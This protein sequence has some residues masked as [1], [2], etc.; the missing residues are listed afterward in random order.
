MHPFIPPSPAEARHFR[1]VGH[2]H[3][4]LAKAAGA[5]VRTDALSGR[6]YISA[7][8]WLLMS[9]PNAL[10]RGA[11]DA[12]DE[13]GV[14]LPTDD[15]GRYNA[16][17]SVMRPEEVA[18]IGGPDK[19]TERG[20]SYRYS[21]G[22]VK[23]VEP[24]TWAGTSKV[25]YITV[26]SPELK[27]LR[28]SYG[29]TP[30]PHNNEFD[31]HVTFATRKTKVLQT[32]DVS[33]AASFEEENEAAKEEAQDSKLPHVREGY[34]RCR[35]GA[36][37]YAMTGDGKCPG[38]RRKM[39]AARGKA[40]AD[41]PT[42]ADWN[43]PSDR[44]D[45]PAC[46]V[47]HERGDGYCNSCGERWPAVT[48][49]AELDAF[50]A[51]AAVEPAEALL[52]AMDKVAGLLGAI[53]KGV[54]KAVGKAAQPVAGV[55]QKAVAAV[56][57]AAQTAASAA[58]TVGHGAVDAAKSV[59][60][61]LKGYAQD[62]A[63]VTP[64][65]PA[66]GVARMAY[67]AATTPFFAPL[68]K[69]RF[70]T[71]T[72]WIGRASNAVAGGSLVAGAATAPGIIRNNVSNGVRNSL[73]MEGVPPAEADGVESEIKKRFLSEMVP[74]IATENTPTARAHRRAVGRLAVPYARDQL[75][76]VTRTG[77]GFLPK[78][79][80]PY[81]GKAIDLARSVNPLGALMTGGMYAARKPMPS[82]QIGEAVR[83]AVGGDPL[84]YVAD[85]PRSG[86]QQSYLRATAPISAGT[87]YDQARQAAAVPGSNVQHG[88]ADPSLPVAR[89]ANHGDGTFAVYQDSG[90]AIQHAISSPVPSRHTFGQA[91][92]MPSVLRRANPVWNVR[93]ADEAADLLAGGG[94]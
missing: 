22:D 8:G 86:L 5:P 69:G 53:G 23:E 41:R 68:T 74:A 93:P 60:R 49:T 20:H 19:I 24:N 2:A 43:D 17:V 47:M 57:A 13:A 73:V 15:N 25:W 65:Q 66:P 7:S 9:V 83:E 39:Y 32:N 42:P 29:L 88:Y 45:C 64:G 59:G 67:N 81:A 82:G 51:D 80:A 78:S 85:M 26:H 37:Y 55:A 4:L 84:G 90:N 16:H 30:L 34:V 27:E 48:K 87:L 89:W 14:E 38:C 44:E 54:T 71:A 1:D 58:K 36:K 40:A 46:G 56:P 61:G 12:L 6:L 72:K 28:R 21:L 33:K 76:A 31:F 62:M 91:A 75:D 50:L 94:G 92:E 3:V 11:F 10:G 70:P 77:P 18:K 79:I 63:G 52:D 35:C